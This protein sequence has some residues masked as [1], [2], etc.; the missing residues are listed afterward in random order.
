MNSII[1][2]GIKNVFVN[3]KIKKKLL[4]YELI[5]CVNIGLKF[6]FYFLGVRY[7]DENLIV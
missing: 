1:T 2:N 3:N 5:Y 7:V 4:K 6:Y